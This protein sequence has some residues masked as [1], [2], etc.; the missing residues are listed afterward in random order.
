MIFCGAVVKVASLCAL[1]ECLKMAVVS[2]DGGQKDDEHKSE[3]I[4]SNS[5]NSPSMC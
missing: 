3:L 2:C 4:F 1:A 5:A